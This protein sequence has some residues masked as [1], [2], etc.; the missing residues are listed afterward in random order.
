MNPEAPPHVCSV[1]V[2][3]RLLCILRYLVNVSTTCGSGLS[4]AGLEGI[5]NHPETTI[6]AAKN[7]CAGGTVVPRACSTRW[8]ERSARV[9]GCG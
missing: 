1:G 6:S 7:A 8:N 4:A 2:E 3:H 9:F 5:G